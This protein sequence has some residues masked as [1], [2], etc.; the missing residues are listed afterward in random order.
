M[1]QTISF[2]LQIKVKTLPSRIGCWDSNVQ[3][4]NLEFPSIT[5]RPGLPS[6][7][8]TVPLATYL[9]T[10]NCSICNVLLKRYIS[11]PITLNYTDWYEIWLCW[12][13]SIHLNFYLILFRV[14][15]A[16]FGSGFDAEFEVHIESSPKMNWFK[17]I[18][19]HGRSPTVT[20]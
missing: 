7:A 13:N 20:R 1:K 5:I 3:P 6:R 14:I 8:L 18:C 4:L 15:L 17:I 2:F 12:T 9:G 16:E 11:F 19:C 10:F